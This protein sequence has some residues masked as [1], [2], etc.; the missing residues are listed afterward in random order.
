MTAIQ[1]IVASA[2]IVARR[3]KMV[4]FARSPVQA[5]SSSVS[6]WVPF[7]TPQRAHS[8]LTLPSDALHLFH[9]LRWDEPPPPAPTE[10]TVRSRTV[11]VSRL[12]RNAEIAFRVDAMVD[13]A[14]TASACSLMVIRTTSDLP[15]VGERCRLPVPDPPETQPWA[16]VCVDEA[17]VRHFS[18]VSGI[19]HPLHEDPEY[20]RH[21][22]F[23]GIVVQGL[24]I[25]QIVL[26]QLGASSP[27]TVSMWFLNPVIAGRWLDTRL[28]KGEGT[29]TLV[30]SDRGTSIRSAV[31][32][33]SDVESLTEKSPPGATSG[34]TTREI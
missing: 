10:M 14:S 16:S 29:S 12:G 24:L 7:L 15:A 11:W 19:H 25:G 17:R 13:S 34:T 5:H 27:G 22:G 9:Q 28:S 21:A 23:G 1:E 6:D 32:R 31:V 30:L 33:V 2:Q 26:E 4:G 18:E 3:V 8:S 20:A